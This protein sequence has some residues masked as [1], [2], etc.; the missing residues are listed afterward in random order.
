MRLTLKKTAILALACACLIGAG[1]AQNKKKVSKITTPTLACGEST[2][3]TI[4]IQ[5]TAPLGGTGMPAGFSIQW[6]TAEDF[7]NGTSENAPGQWPT[8]SDAAAA[9]G[10]LCKGSFSGNANLTN[11]N[12]LAGESRDITIGTLQELIENSQLPGGGPSG[13]VSSSCPGE[14]MC[15]TDY[16][17]RAFGHA[18]NT[19]FRSDFTPTLTCST[20]TCLEEQPD[21]F[22]SFT[23]G[24]WG[25]N[26]PDSQ[27][28]GTPPDQPGCI[29]DNNFSSVYPAGVM[30]GGA[31]KMTFTS[32]GAVASYLP[33]G[34]MPSVLTGNLLNPTSSP[35]GVFG[36]QVT[37]LRLNV[38]MSDAGVTSMGF[39]DASLCN[40]AAGNLALGGSA[41][42][43]AQ[44]GALNGTSIRG[45]LAAAENRLGGSTLPF[46]LSAGQLTSLVT[47]LNESYDG[48]L[49]DAPCGDPSAFATDFI[50]TP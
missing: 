4:T 35:A 31:F 37:T 34:G 12:L 6:M 39:G 29:R 8:D 27:G 43:A 16:V 50:C 25:S 24:G 46:G 49:P 28:P 42:T 21:S 17:F 33:A 36:G 48:P 2:S 41:L 5:I 11:W 1:F 10:I 14:L 23:Q 9:A 26:C 3:E 38:D 20:D 40:F 13:G 18:T 19:L 44:A 47:L 32:S 30:V 22:C 15:D 45:V 7:Y